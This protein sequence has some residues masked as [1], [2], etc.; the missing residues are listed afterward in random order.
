MNNS[1]RNICQDQHTSVLGSRYVALADMKKKQQAP[2]AG[3]LEEEKQR[4]FDEVEAV[5]VAQKHRE[6]GISTS[7][8]RIKPES[9]LSQESVGAKAGDSVHIWKHKCCMRVGLNF[10]PSWLNEPHVDQIP[11]YER[12][13]LVQWKFNSASFKLV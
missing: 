13:H 8:I 1:T 2:S 5:L 4:N 11:G 12:H 3:S 6:S 7:M 9:D 10:Q